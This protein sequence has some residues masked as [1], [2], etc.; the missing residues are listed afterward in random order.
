MIS[1][2]LLLLAN[3]SFISTKMGNVEIQKV[4]EYEH[5]LLFNGKRIEKFEE[6][7]VNFKEHYEG[8]TKS[9]IVLSI[10]TGTSMIKPEY[11][12]IEIRNGNISV[13]NRV[14][15]YDYTFKVT[16]ATSKKIIMDLGL[17]A[18]GNKRTATYQ[19]GKIKVLEAQ[20]KFNATTSMA[21]IEAQ[22][23]TIHANLNSF[24]R[25][26]HRLEGYPIE[27]NDG[28]LVIYKKDNFDVKYVEATLYTDG[29]TNKMK[30]YF[31][32][33]KP[34]YVEESLSYSAAMAQAAGIP[35]N[36]K[37]IKKYYFTNHKLSRYEDNSGT[38]K[39]TA[40]EHHETYI[41][42][43]ANAIVNRNVCDQ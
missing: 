23:R 4:H 10:D 40:L 8:S 20:P 18:D 33:N 42:K 41:M 14:I 16:K 7:Y 39:T 15:S 27:A 26:E 1:T 19:N 11:A 43:I 24:F 25:N 34:F 30:L 35:A 3:D 32:D 17:S 28:N 21:D 5:W 6:R 2:T 29:T 13:S 36:Q 37:D 31:K 22:K 38:T 12:I 9:I